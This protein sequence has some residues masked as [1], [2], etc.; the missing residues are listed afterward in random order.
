MPDR[1]SHRATR[2]SCA[3]ALLALTAGAGA[4]PASADAASP[5]PAAAAQQC[6]GLP[7][8]GFNISSLKL[9]A[10]PIHDQ[11]V[12]RLMQELVHVGPGDRKAILGTGGTRDAAVRKQVDAAVRSLCVGELVRYAT[13]RAAVE[14]GFAWDTADDARLE[15][16]ANGP[17]VVAIGA[18]AARASLDSA[19]LDAA[20]HGLPLPDP[21][22]GASP[23]PAP[24]TGDEN[25]WTI[26]D[27]KEP[28]YPPPALKAGEIG[29]VKLDVALDSLGYVTAVKIHTVDLDLDPA[30]GGGQMILGS[31]ISAA[32]AR[33][34]PAHPGCTP[35]AANFIYKVDFS[36]NGVAVSE[37]R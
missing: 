3:L 27:A 20:L 2:W 26:R 13:L 29:N 5:P 9:F 4:V 7:S 14:L 31:L 23:L 25:V 12:L 34:K 11:G 36:Y 1:F 28:L 30:R 18:V 8:S 21:D 15:A 17:L 35:V 32:A 24:C 16:F 19:V 6:E 33:F 10:Y 22:P 37:S